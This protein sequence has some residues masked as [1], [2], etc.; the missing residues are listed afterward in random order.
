[1]MDRTDTSV[2]EAV[3]A[4]YATLDGQTP[5]RVA[6]GTLSR[7][8]DAR[9]AM[10]VLERGAQGVADLHQFGFE[11]RWLEDYRT[12]W[13]ARSPYLPRLYESPLRAGRFVASGELVPYEDWI[14]SEMFEA[15]GRAQDVHHGAATWFH[16]TD[17]MTV[18]LS[19]TR[20]AARGPFRSAD[21]ERLDHLVPHLAQ[22]V[23]LAHAFPDPLGDRLDACEAIGVAALIVDAELQVQQCNDAAL[24]VLQG[25]PA[26]APRTDALTPADEA[27]RASLAELVAQVTNAGGQH[28]LRLADPDDRAPP[29]SL[30]LTRAP[31]RVPV[32][33]GDERSRDER[34]LVT[35][36]RRD[37]PD[38]LSRELLHALYQLTPAETQLARLIASGYSP[39]QAAKSLEV[40]ISTVR[41]HLKRIFA[42]TGVAG[43]TELATLIQ[44][45]AHTA[46]VVDEARS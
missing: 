41:W 44:S 24:R 30:L 9:G 34:V 38:R 28:Q 21:I 37:G 27:A 12:N 33:A 17:G 20:D 29:L 2:L 26:L 31:S 6:L 40:R 19:L 13:A 46:P 10:L 36:V 42:K 1:M 32:L 14:A 18:R 8:F 16:A 3:S 23:R 35:V 4:L 45:L 39:D 5:W 7:I 11:E 25:S 15:S 22:A 43:Q